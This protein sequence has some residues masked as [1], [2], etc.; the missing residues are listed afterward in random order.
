MNTRAPAGFSIAGVLRIVGQARLCL[1]P[2]SAALLLGTA[3][4]PDHAIAQSFTVNSGSTAVTTRTMTGTGDIGLIEFG[5]TLGPVAGNGVNMIGDDQRLDNF[6]LIE[7]VGAGAY[8]LRSTGQNVSIHNAGTIDTSG[9]N[10]NGINAT[11]GSADIVNDGLI[12]VDAG[13]GVRLDGDDA[14]LT[15]NGTIAADGSSLAVY[16]TGLHANFVNYGTIQSAGSSGVAASEDGYLVNYGSV[17]IQGSNGFGLS[18]G[19]GGRIENYGLVSTTGD[20]GTG[21]FNNTG[22]LDGIYAYNYG[23]VVTTGRSARG[24]YWGGNNGH[25]LNAGAIE[26]HGLRAAGV[27]LLGDGI[28]MEN[29]GTVLTTGDTETGISASGIQAAPSADQTLI[30]N[31]G[32]I[33]ATGVGGRGI[34]IEGTNASIVNSGSIVSAQSNAIE[35]RNG[36]ARLELLAGTAI[37]GNIRFAGTGNTVSFGPGLNARM[38]FSGAG[39][40]GTVIAGS[41]PAVITGNSIAVLDRAGFALADD[42]SLALLGTLSD[43]EKGAGLCVGEEVDTECDV[44]AWLSGIGGFDRQA[45]SSELAGYGYGL[46][47]LVAGLEF[48]PGDG[49]SAGAF[50]GGAAAAGEVAASQET[51]LT[52][53]IAGAHLGFARGSV[54]ANFYAAL[55]IVGIDSRRSVA[56]NLVDRGLAEA[57]AETTGYA[58]TPSAT[59]GVNLDTP[60]GV[61]TPSLRARYSRLMLDGYAESGAADTLVVDARTAE[62]AELRLQLALTL[63]AGEAATTTLR[64]GVDATH[65]QSSVVAELAGQPIAFDPGNSGVSYGG[66]AGIDFAYQLADGASLEAYSELAFDPTG[67]SAAGQLGYRKA[68]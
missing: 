36:A 62:E 5:G 14:T 22:G 25:L 11:G 55:G 26:T 29:D 16:L 60:L 52:G 20:F 45:G 58:F 15:N 37:D 38:S 66:F 49:F 27:L 63:G 46:G 64:G 13:F 57:S 33:E 61:L 31:R 8:G 2:L 34:L 43:A 65:R 67:I 32:S 28:V 17:L 30:I 18:V 9:T 59:V 41:N 54:F 40:P 19:L 51:R 68:F 50:V 1:V 3:L 48:K 6:G 21:I 44:S 24:M 56:D 42:M 47:G 12:H 53:G 39:M 7:T 10:A 35:F 4:S 23:T